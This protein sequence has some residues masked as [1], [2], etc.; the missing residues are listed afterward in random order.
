M[1]K[2]TSSY[3]VRLFYSYSHKDSGF[4][5]TMEDS[6]SI[7]RRN[8]ILTTWSDVS[9]VPGQPISA[10][11]RNEMDRADIMVFLLSHNFLA[12]DPCMEEWE[13]A[14]TRS[15]TGLLVRIPIVLSDCPWPD[16]L[17]GDDIKALP[18]DGHPVDE[19]D[20]QSKAWTQ[21]Y[22]GIKSTIFV[23]RS[24][25]SPKSAF[26]QEISQTPFVGRR[27]ISLQDVFTFPT[28]SFYSSRKSSS[29][30]T[31]RSIT[32]LKDLLLEDRILIY[33]PEL[34]GK[35]SL[36]K[37]L[38]ISLLDESSP[39]IFVDLNEVGS[40][41]FSRV[42]PE[43][44]RKQF[45][46]DYDLWENQ[47]NRTLIVDNLS[48]SAQSITFVANAAEHFDRVIVACPSDVFHAFLADD[49]RL[50]DFVSVSIAP[51]THAQQESLIRER[52]SFVTDGEP[53]T[54]GR[55]D[56]IESHVNSIITS[57]RIVPRY[58]FFVLSILQTYETFLPEMHITSY[59]YCYHVLIVTNLV[60]AGIPRTDDGIGTAFIFAERLAFEL[61]ETQRDASP[62]DFQTFVVDYNKRFI[63]PDAIL[64]R[65]QHP[66]YG[67]IFSDGR[68][69]TEYMYYYFVGLYLSRDTRGYES[70]ITSM[71]DNIH[72]GKN[73]LTLLF[74][75][76]HTNDIWIIDE[77]L[78]RIRCA[79][80][81]AK[82]ATLTQEETRRFGEI[83]DTLSEN[84]LSDRD[85]TSQRR[86]MRDIRDAGDD[87][88]VSDEMESVDP[89]SFGSH[90]YK[91]FR[92]NGI[93]GQVLRNKYGILERSRVE[94]I[95]EEVA[96]SS[97]R[98]VNS[99]LRDESEIEHRAHY[100]HRKHPEY[101][102]D[103]LRTVLRLL[104][105]LWTMVHIGIAVESINHP[106]V[107]DVV[108]KVVKR[109]STPA[110][111]LIGYF[112][113]LHGAT[114]LTEGL[115]DVLKRLLDRHSDRF[116]RGVLSLSTQHYMNTHRSK[117]SVEQSVCSLLELHYVSR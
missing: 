5:Q 57:R 28:L 53:I 103:R 101:G 42:I 110:Y 92:S 64:S 10:R 99:L 8:Q 26:V 52:M 7:L 117:A 68:F 55:I 33:G 38:Y 88:D 94:E 45:S 91:M 12:S 90:C 20:N 89:D 108:D 111:D 40:R 32:N 19:F 49:E 29:G 50:V 62:F 78:S 37:H 4:R 116:V 104:S 69:R 75:I 3:S 23:L 63:I 11:I 72:I 36:L 16:L 112:S 35:S 61:Y 115:R 71:C 17:D 81:S 21:I 25:F 96:D 59:G 83:V 22:R 113:R 13:A 76:H 58:P 34:S 82:P 14:K 102:V 27:P 18:D 15:A 107:R 1:S 48:S 105:F 66:D 100:Y 73:H 30:M 85:V 74:I 65:L 67:I 43:S 6:L 2:H 97:L 98:I 60:K 31:E 51:L 54:D 109:K 24:T 80:E 95:I 93:L 70:L 44:Y 47:T 41:S 46:G 39:A 86:E 79:F 56:Q 84:I 114:E 106:D 9:I 77:I 87:H